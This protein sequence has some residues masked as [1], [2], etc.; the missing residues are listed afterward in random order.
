MRFFL[1][2]AMLLSAVA[3][4]KDDAAQWKEWVPAGWKLI[5]TANGDLNH[6]G[7]VDAVLVLEQNK[8]SN[9]VK[10][11][12]L[13]AQELNLNPRRLLI[14]F[15]AASGYEKVLSLDNYLPS[16]NSEDSPC[17]DDPLSEGG[18]QVNRGLLKISF[19]YWMSCGSWG[20]SH[21]TFT[22][23]YESSRFRLIGL[24]TWGFM[25]NTGE[26]SET[27]VNFLT[28]K[29]K[30]VSGL[31]EFDESESKPKTSWLK[32]KQTRPLYLDELVSYC[33]SSASED[34]CN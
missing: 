14:L 28:G 11:E 29:K 10:N 12:S 17:L 25:R 4:G 22:F 5:Q 16:Q 32:I 6:D 7:K 8:K 31:N 20:V 9:F 13:G 1:F 3:F 30:M 34:L 18:I 19:R 33:K 27:S 23:R 21:R 15:Q 24:D 2:G 26:K